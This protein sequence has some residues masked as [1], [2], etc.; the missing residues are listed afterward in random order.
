[1][2][3]LAWFTVAFLLL[4]GAD[5]W[6]DTEV[7]PRER[8]GVIDA[9]ESDSESDAVGEVERPSCLEALDGLGVDYERARRSGIRTGVKVRGSIGGVEFRSYKKGTP[10]VLDCSLIYSLALSAPILLRSGIEVVRYS[11]AYDR[12]NIR[13]TR[14]PSKHSYGLAIDLHTFLSP[15]ATYTV[16]EDYEQGLGEDVDCVGE[17]LTEAGATL[18]EID[19]ELNRSDLYRI[20]LTPD[21]DADHYNHFHVEALPWGERTDPVQPVQ[22]PSAEQ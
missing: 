7:A 10:L 17:P 20:V 5:A 2:R 12:R 14:R 22:A 4:H 11:S 18:R 16:K 21:F 1:M 8:T 19:C 3:F 6:A 15:G 13:G 9:S